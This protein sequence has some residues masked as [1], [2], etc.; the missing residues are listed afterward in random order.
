MM[1][2][3]KSNLRVKSQKRKSLKYNM[4]QFRKIKLL[5]KLIKNN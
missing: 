3:L 2:K 5:P 1:K 4:K